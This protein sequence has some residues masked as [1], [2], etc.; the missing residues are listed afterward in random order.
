MAHELAE[1]IGE[2]TIESLPIELN[3]DYR[4][5][6]RSFIEEMYKET[7]QQAS[8]LD[9]EHEKQREL[10]EQLRTK[11]QEIDEI[12]DKYEKTIA[13]SE[14]EQSDKLSLKL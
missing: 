13:D 2:G 10:E 4:D 3:S 14:K 7:K 5:I 8:R 11:E 6:F 12:I 1:K 9:K